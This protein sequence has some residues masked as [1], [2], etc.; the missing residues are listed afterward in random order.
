MRNLIFHGESAPWRIL[1]I[2]IWFFASFYQLPI[3]YY[4]GLHNY[5]VHIVSPL[6]TSDFRLPCSLLPAPCSLLPAPCSLQT[7][8]F[9]PN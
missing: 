9:V 4:G 6:P 8:N 2:K 3:D 1:S 5:Q 7:Q